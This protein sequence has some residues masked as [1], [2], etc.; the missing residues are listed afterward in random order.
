MAFSREKAQKAQKGGMQLPPAYS[1]V[2]ASL[3]PFRGWIGLRSAAVV[4]IS[5]EVLG[6]GP[7]REPQ[8]GAES[9]KR[10][11]YS[12]IRFPYLLL[13]RVLRDREGG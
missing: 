11:Q 7:G 12:Y 8:K 4:F 6:D 10:G 3:A 13:R 5:R 2:F 9:A 1:S